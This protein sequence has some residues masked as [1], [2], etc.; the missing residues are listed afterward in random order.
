MTIFANQF[1]EVIG[2]WVLE[3]NEESGL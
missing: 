1:S 3:R 2:H